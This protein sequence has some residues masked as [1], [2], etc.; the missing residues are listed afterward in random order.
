VNQ[1][2]IARLER[3]TLSGMRLSTL[4]RVL[5]QLSVPPDALLLAEGPPA[6]T[7]RLPGSTAD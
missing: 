5:G 3:G 7:R 2:T 4:A 6:P 1:S